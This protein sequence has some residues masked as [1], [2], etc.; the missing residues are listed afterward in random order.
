MYSP[1]QIATG[2]KMTTAS[3]FWDK[4]AVRY[5]K[6]P[7][8]DEDAYR[9]KLAKTREYLSPTSQVLEIGCGTGSTALL[10][11]P[12]VA[13]IRATD[14]SEQMLEIARDKAQEQGITNVTFEKDDISALQPVDAQYDAVLAMS[15]LHLLRDK[16]GAIAKV[17]R[18]LKPGGVFV[19][20][21]ACLGDRL[22]F[23]KVLAPIGRAV[24]L[25][26]VLNVMSQTELVHS[27]EATG[28]T[29]DHFWHP[30]GIAA[31]FIVAKKP[32]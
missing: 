1:H 7:I 19:S 13:H 31:V 29:V 12:F 28:F 18:M 3:R 24:G 30:G 10:H 6:Q 17:Y 20:S 26:P 25:L 23:F 4:M 16:D 15:V 22:A 14:F 8:A 21:T 32:T 27:L 9:K 5:S 2:D 11:A